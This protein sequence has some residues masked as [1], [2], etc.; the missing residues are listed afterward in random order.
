MLSVLAYVALAFFF[1][2]MYGSIGNIMS[3]LYQNAILRLANN[4][5]G[6]F[7]FIMFP[8]KTL[9]V[10][11]NDILK[12]IRNNSCGPEVFNEFPAVCAD[13]VKVNNSSGLR[14][15][16]VIGRYDRKDV[17][18]YWTKHRITMS[19]LWPA[20][21]LISFL[22]LLT[23]SVIF[24]VFILYY[25]FKGIEKLMNNHEYIAA[26][27][28]YLFSR[29]IKDGV[30]PNSHPYRNKNVAVASSEKQ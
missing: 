13:D 10:S 5:R 16:E 22:Q 27:I 7:T 12:D 19:F 23:F 3:R 30:D 29:S 9:F 1:I 20:R 8:Q 15:Y 14:S 6:L 2:V 11:H 28:K 25:I 26:R 17:D 18:D 21:F 24:P 4:K